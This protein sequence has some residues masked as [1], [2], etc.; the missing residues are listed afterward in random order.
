MLEDFGFREVRPSDTD[1]SYDGRGLGAAHFAN[2]LDHSDLRR[3][4]RGALEAH[5]EVALSSGIDVA[6]EL[7]YE[8]PWVE[9]LEEAEAA[10]YDMLQCPDAPIPRD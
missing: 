5:D 1:E 10:L 6:R 2:S 3:D 9:E 4:I 7:G 8:Y